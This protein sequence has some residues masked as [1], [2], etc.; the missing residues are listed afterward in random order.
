MQRWRTFALAISV[1]LLASSCAGAWTSPSASRYP[2]PA[3]LEELRL[4]Q[5]ANKGRVYLSTPSEAAI[6]PVV[7]MTAAAWSALIG[8][9]AR[10]VRGYCEGRE[11]LQVANGDRPDPAP[12][13]RPTEAAR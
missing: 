1:L 2:V 13:C 6:V 12:V 10:L 9:V 7:G 8:H 3:A 5:Q 11:A 4:D